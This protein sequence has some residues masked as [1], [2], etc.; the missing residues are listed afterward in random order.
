MI[1]YR[2]NIHKQLSAIIMILIAILL[3]SCI[4][5]N[6][7]DCPD[8][9]SLR[10]EYMLNEDYRDL[11]RSQVTHLDLLVYNAQGDYLTTHTILQNQLKDGN[12]FPLDMLQAGTY[13]FV[14][15][16]NTTGSL[17]TKHYPSRIEDMYVKLNLTSDG[18]A[19]PLHG[20]LFH[21]I[22]KMTIDPAAQA[23]QTM[24]LTKNTHLLHIILEETGNNQPSRLGDYSVE[25][26]GSNGTYNYQN[27][28]T[29][30]DLLHYKSRYSLTGTNTIQ[31]DFTLLRLLVGDD[32]RIQIKAADGTVIYN[33]L[34]T[35][36]IMQSPNYLT[37]ED[38]D[39]TDEY[40]LKY[41][42]QKAPG[43]WTVS[44]IKIN[45]WDVIEQ[46]GGIH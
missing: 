46:G 25:I 44:L 6:M 33:E 10:F 18:Q 8:E 13:T 29:G 17:Y 22:T 23:S 12:S 19:D 2:K 3:P 43:G 5:D 37:D 7:D 15:W 38:L 16:G 32:L 20:S 21:G 26:S 45:E 41:N 34:L 28:T 11:F 14:A 42:I 30:T 36:K 35:A 31:V 9:S 4:G 27:Q 39:R 24:Y 40:I 1:F